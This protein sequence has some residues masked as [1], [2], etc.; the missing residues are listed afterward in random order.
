MDK[1]GC[2]LVSAHRS[3]GWRPLHRGSVPWKCKYI[4]LSNQREPQRSCHRPDR[5]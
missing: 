1:T 4:R 2:G 3:I 5:S